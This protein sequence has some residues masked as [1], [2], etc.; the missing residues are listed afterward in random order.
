MMKA[1]AKDIQDRQ[2]AE[3][4]VHLACLDSLDKLSLRDQRSGEKYRE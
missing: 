4:Y 1:K 2:R 3:L